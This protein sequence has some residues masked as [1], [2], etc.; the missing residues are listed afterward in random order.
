MKI[1]RLK[2]E[3]LF[4]ENKV[5]LFANDIH[6]WDFRLTELSEFL[7]KYKDVLSDEEMERINQFQLCVDKI[8]CAAGKIITRL[9]LAQYLEVDN[10]IIVIKYGKYGRPFHY[11]IK[12]KRS[13]QFS[14][15]HSGNVLLI[16]FSHLAHIGIDI[17]Q[18][19]S[20]SEYRDIAKFF[21]T[22]EEYIVVDESKSLEV[23]YQYWTAKEAYLKAMGIG[24]VNGMNFFTIKNT[25]IIEKG[26]KKDNWVL[27][28]L[29][30]DPGYAACV[31]AHT[32]LQKY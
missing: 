6:I 27:F 4:D 19:K 14:I 11:T 17:E 7:P 24:L 2:Y 28:P 25:S 1:H 30:I 31:A 21:F 16:A 10:R 13:V 15:S 32:R 12:G 9:L 23:F 3:N 20:F 8:R 18:I 5:R 29:E 22:E 26:K